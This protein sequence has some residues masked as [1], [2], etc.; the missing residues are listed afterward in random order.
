MMLR[1]I[2]MGV[3][4]LHRSTGLCLVTSG[5]AT[6]RE[7]EQK[8]EGELSRQKSRVARLSWQPLSSNADGMPAVETPR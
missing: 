3:L 8:Q 7:L 6:E 1:M 4:S 2:R 5:R